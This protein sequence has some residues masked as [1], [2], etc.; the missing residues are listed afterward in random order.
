MNIAENL[1]QL[2]FDPGM[3]TMSEE[4]DVITIP[5]LIAELVEAMIP[6]LP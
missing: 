6:M 4:Q 2:D 1:P 5:V 3:A